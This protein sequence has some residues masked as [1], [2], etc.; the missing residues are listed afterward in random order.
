MIF[1]L[2]GP[3]I[4]AIICGV[5][6]ILAYIIPKLKLKHSIVNY[7]NYDINN[8]N[9]FWGYCGLGG[10]GYMG[11]KIT[12]KPITHANGNSSVPLEG[13]PNPLPNVNTNLLDPNCNIM[14][15]HNNDLFFGVRVEVLCNID[16]NGCVHPWDNVLAGHWDQYVA[17][18]A[19]STKRK[20]I[21]ETLQNKEIIDEMKGA[22]IPNTFDEKPF[23]G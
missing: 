15:K 4:V 11:L 19:A 18:L 17:S 9:A 5:L 23:R 1:G 10:P 13:L 21:E 8:S 20:A 7:D 14:V 12:A 3:V 2:D 22:Q 16:A 6:I